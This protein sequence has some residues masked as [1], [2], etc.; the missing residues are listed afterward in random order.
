VFN[1]SLNR[2]IIEQTRLQEKPINNGMIQIDGTI[3]QINSECH[4]A[5]HVID[6]LITE[7]VKQKFII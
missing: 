3:R 5:R 6:N 7:V 2:H 4:M 1:C